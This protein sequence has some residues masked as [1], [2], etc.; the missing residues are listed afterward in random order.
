MKPALPLPLRKAWI[1]A[2]AA[3]L[4]SP[5]MARDEAMPL[6][7]DTGQP[8]ALLL[9]GEGRALPILTDP[10]DADVVRRAAA[11]LAQDAGVGGAQVLGHVGE[12]VDAEMHTLQ[13]VAQG[14]GHALGAGHAHVGLAQ[15]GDADLVLPGVDGL[16]G[17]ARELNG[18]LLVNPYDVDGTAH[19][20]A[21]A[22][23]MSR[24]ER[25]DRWRQMMD[26]LLTND[27]SH[28]CRSFLADLTR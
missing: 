23:T 4:A 18:A 15:R 24:E 26:V 2:I 21:R 27:V 12:E 10:H 28:W 3:L 16:A 6:V 11:D 13:D 22:L 7:H 17:A 5:A 8:G 1:L 9:A 20:L 25:R 14:V 19:A